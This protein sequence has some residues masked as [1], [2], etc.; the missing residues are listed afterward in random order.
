MFFYDV[1]GLLTIASDVVLPELASFVAPGSGPDR[2]MLRVR[3]RSWLG[4][5]SLTAG[6]DTTVYDEGLAGLGFGVRIA[7]GERIEVEASTL[8]RRSP[9]V[10][11]TNVVEP[12]L[13]WTFVRKGWALIHG[14]CV[15]VGGDA[16]LITARTDTGKTTT[17]LTLLRR[18]S[19]TTSAW[20][21]R[22]A[23]CSPTRSR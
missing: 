11:Y 18:S 9:H 13:R 15:G 19:P 4:R 3:V 7:L 6:D 16:Y 2:A 10:L 22:T 1:H 12:I 14:A 5:H 21:T 23:G 8:L 20:S 17:L